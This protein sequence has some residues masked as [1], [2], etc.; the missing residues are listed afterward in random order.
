MNNKVGYLNIIL[1]PMFSGKTTYLINAYNNNINDN[2][3]TLAIN[4]AL[5]DRYGNGKIVSHDG[6]SIPCT[7]MSKLSEIYKTNFK[8]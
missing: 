8:I 3:S 5:D 2:I 7:D 4:H 1:G 6:N